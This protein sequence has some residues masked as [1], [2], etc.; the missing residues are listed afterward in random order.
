M[1]NAQNQLLHWHENPVTQ[2]TRSDISAFS[3]SSNG[4]STR[5]FAD[6][7]AV[8]D[9]WDILFRGLCQDPSSRSDEARTLTTLIEQEDK[10][11]DSPPGNPLTDFSW[12]FQ[13]TSVLLNTSCSIEHNQWKWN[14]QH[15]NE[16][17]NI[18][19][20]YTDY[21]QHV[22]TMVYQFRIQLGAHTFVPHS[23]S[24]GI[25]LPGRKGLNLLQ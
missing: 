19:K 11:F 7:S 12:G 5:V 21:R 25:P 8:N 23:Q 13:T 14:R 16:T 22:Y 1:H 3:N 4:L 24:P 10:H 17:D 18:A 9:F 20:A 6:I 15:E 2:R